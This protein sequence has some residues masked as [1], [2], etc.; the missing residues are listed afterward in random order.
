MHEFYTVSRK[1]ISNLKELT[2]F[3]SS[4]DE[5]Y[6][7]TNL[8]TQNEAKHKIKELFPNG[9]SSH[10]KQYLHDKYNYIYDANK[11]SYVSYLHIIE[12][13][14]ELVRQIKFKDK[15]SRF[16]SIFGWETIEEAIKFRLEKGKP[17]DKIYK[18][19]TKSFVKADMNLLYTATIPG[20]III[21]EKYWNGESSQN[22]C[23]EILMTAPVKILSEIYIPKN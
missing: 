9:I 14:F 17:T 11:T 7:V 5:I 2:L 22:P 20:N 19:S 13:T 18:V 6:E 10:G 21:A 8:F 3:D 12:I 15:L 4:P 23:W 1:D 16:E